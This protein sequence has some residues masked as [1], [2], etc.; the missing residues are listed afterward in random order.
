MAHLSV[1]FPYTLVYLS[2]RVGGCQ[3]GPARQTRKQTGKMILLYVHVA[4]EF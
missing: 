1:D 3:R 2:V 4:T